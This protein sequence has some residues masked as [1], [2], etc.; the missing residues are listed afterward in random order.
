MIIPTYLNLC[1]KHPIKSDNIN[2]FDFIFNEYYKKN[3]NFSEL[4]NTSIIATERY[5]L[6]NKSYCEVLNIIEENYDFFIKRYNSIPP[7]TLNQQYPN[8]YFDN[9]NY[10]FNQNP[11]YDE[12]DI[13]GICHMTDKNIISKFK[14]II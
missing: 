11:S 6:I 7:I 1:Y 5:D 13:N 3:L 14:T 8:L 2:D 9:I 10:L 12:L 4:N